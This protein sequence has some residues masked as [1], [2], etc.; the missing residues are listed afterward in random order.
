[1]L[2]RIRKE[3]GLT[4]EQLGF[5]A[6]L[7]RNF[8]SMLEL[9]QGQPTLT[10]IYRLSSPLNATAPAIIAQVD[11]ELAKVSHRSRSK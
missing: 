2:R 6:E 3:A 5:E 9:G 1:V 11:V 8:I 10:T 7:E 4:Q